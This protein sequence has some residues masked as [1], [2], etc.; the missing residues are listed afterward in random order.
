MGK[1]SKRMAKNRQKAQQDSGRQQL[2]ALKKDFE[3]KYAN[4]EYEDALEAL[5]KLLEAGCRDVQ[6]IYQGAMSYFMIGDYTRATEWVSNTLSFDPAHMDA[7]IL[8]ARICIV[9]DR[10]EDGLAILEFVL[11]NW[12]DVL[13]QEQQDTLDDILGY[14][15]KYEMEKLQQHYPQIAAYCQKEQSAGD[16]SLVAENETETVEENLVTDEQQPE[17]KEDGLAAAAAN[18]RSLMQKVKAAEQRETVSPMVAS[19]AESIEQNRPMDDDVKDTI[20]DTVEDAA[21]RAAEDV[22]GKAQSAKA[23]IL[24]KQVSLIEKIKLLNTFAGA[25][26]YENQLDAA[27]LLL[28]AALELDAFQTETLRNMVYTKLAQGEAE[29]AMQYAARMSMPDFGLLQAL[30]GC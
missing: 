17:P 16:A 4:G 19:P 15:A 30:R 2:G 9:E 23:E 12:R 24:Q 26:F 14:Y 20:Q 10:A 11:E 21:D 22:V 18:M 6:Y 3:G 25:Y 8:L 29:A 27:G 28:D 13:R 5:E 1:A 7:R